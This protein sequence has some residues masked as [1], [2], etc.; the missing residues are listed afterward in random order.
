MKPKP[1]P[2]LIAAFI[3]KWQPVGEVEQRPFSRWLT[4]NGAS[5]API[6]DFRNDYRRDNAERPLRV[7]AVRGAPSVALHPA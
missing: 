2:A 6:R 1:T 5:C 7:F 3:A 4:P